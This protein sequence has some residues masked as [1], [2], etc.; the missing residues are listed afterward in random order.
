MMKRFLWNTLGIS[1][2]V[3]MIGIPGGFE[4]GGEVTAGKLLLLVASI[5]VTFLYVLTI[6]YRKI[7]KT[8]GGV[9]YDYRHT[10]PRSRKF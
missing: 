1:A 6:Y 2:I 3:M 5:I 8:S 9:G 10:S 4:T 7:N